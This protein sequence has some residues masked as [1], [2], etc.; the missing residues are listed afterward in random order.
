MILLYEGPF[1]FHG[2]GLIFLFFGGYRLIQRSLTVD[3]PILPHQLMG[4]TWAEAT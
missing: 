1:Y 2:Y 3:I 4:A